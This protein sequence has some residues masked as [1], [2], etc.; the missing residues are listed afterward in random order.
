M[1]TDSSAVKPGPALFLFAGG[2][3]WACHAGDVL[4]RAGTVAPE[5]LRPIPVLGFVGRQCFFDLGGPRISW[6]MMAMAAP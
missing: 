4:G 2:Q 6:R 1:M 3:R 5:F